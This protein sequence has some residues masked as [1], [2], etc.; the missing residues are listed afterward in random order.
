MAKLEIP[1]NNPRTYPGHSGVDFPQAAGTPFLASDSGVVDRWGY[2]SRGGFYIWVKYDSISPKVGYHH[3]PSHAE[4]PRQGSRFKY[5]DKLGVVG[6]TGNSTGPHLH[7][8]VEGHATTDGYWKFFDRSSV[9]SLP[10]S[11]GQSSTTNREDEEM[12]I[13]Y[14]NVPGEAG[15]RRGGCYAVMRDNNGKLFARFVAP[16]KLAGVPTLQNGRAL[17]EFQASIPGLA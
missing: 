14:I 10:G 17:D 2:N 3:L 16:K 15:K 8:E 5:R 9:I 1:F 6:S 11:S 4:C 12:P 7:S 13:S